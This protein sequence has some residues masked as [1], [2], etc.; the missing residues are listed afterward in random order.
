MPCTCPPLPDDAI[1][2]CNEKKPYE[3]V[4]RDWKAY[5]DGV[6]FGDVISISKDRI[7]IKHDPRGVNNTTITAFTGEVPSVELGFKTKD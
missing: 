2:S 3:W 7:K 5:C 4:I 6:F 1:L